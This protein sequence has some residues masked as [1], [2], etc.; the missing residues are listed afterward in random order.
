MYLT[1]LAAYD[2]CTAVSYSSEET[3]AVYGPR[4]IDGISAKGIEVSAL[5]VFTSE[6]SFSTSKNSLKQQNTKK[7]KE[8]GEGYGKA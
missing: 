5:W 2:G 6:S 3:F 1:H 4:A 8:Q 7:L